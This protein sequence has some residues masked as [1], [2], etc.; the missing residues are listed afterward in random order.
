MKK[1]EILIK[2]IEENGGKISNIT[3]NDKRQILATKELDI[4]EKIM[5]IPKKLHITGNMEQVM[6]KLIQE[7]NVGDK[8]FYYPYLNIL[9]T[10]GD[11]KDHPLVITQKKGNEFLRKCIPISTEF[12]SYI[13][14]LSKMFNNIRDRLLV[15]GTSPNTNFM[16]Y[17]LLIQTRAWITKE[18]DGELMVS[19]IPAMDL[20]QHCNV[21]TSFGTMEKDG[22]FTM[23]TNFK[24][25]KGSEVYD[26]YG[27][28]DNIML[29]AQ[30]NF[31]AIPPIQ[32][33]DIETANKVLDKE[34]KRIKMYYNDHP[35]FTS[36]GPN[37]CLLASFRVLNTELKKLEML[38]KQDENYFAQIYD[39]N[40]EQKSL[41][42]ILN[43][44][45]ESKISKITFSPN[46]EPVIYNLKL[47]V[48]DKNTIFKNIL[49]AI[50]HYCPDDYIF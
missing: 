24:Y 8:S 31:R 13:I 44:I 27:F 3:M 6:F 48:H 36:K 4:G 19:M 45:K 38:K 33:V 5:K 7:M 35:Y 47:A 42:Q 34:L 16:Y 12:T 26:S 21:G 50:Q 28:K 49:E 10:F 39:I 43:A 17:F 40:V 20:L 41:K 46:D 32:P 29:L 15:G 9:P 25:E 18:G 1:W 37:E 2:W 11:F 14:E 22:N 30:Y 23:K